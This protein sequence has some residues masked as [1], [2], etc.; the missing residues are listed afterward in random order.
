MA[1]TEH[2]DLGVPEIY[3]VTFRQ[4][5]QDALGIRGLIG[6]GPEAII[7]LHDATPQGH[8]QHRP[9]YKRM[10]STLVSRRDI[11]STANTTPLELTATDAIGVTCRRKIGPVDV[12][13]DAGRISHM[14]EPAI[15][16]EIATQAAEEYAANFQTSAISALMGIVASMSGTPHTLSVW[17]ATNRTNLDLDLIARGTGLMGDRDTDLRAIIMHSLVKTDLLRSQ[18][19][20]GFDTGA[21]AVMNEFDRI[22]TLGLTRVAL[23]HDSLKTADAGFNKFHTLLLGVNA[24]FVSMLTNVVYPQQMDLL[25]EQVIKRWR[26]DVDFAI[27][28]PAAQWDVTN[29]GANPTDAALATSTNWDGAAGANPYTDSREVKIVQLTH[30]TRTE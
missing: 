21:G 11:T 26:A 30:N 25:P 10:G 28:C 5:L 18:L 7:K 14:S 9:T 1:V 13:A 17:N 2:G 8:Y 15:W 23:Q 12:S 22:A 16:V 24:L 6:T 3:D 20:M 27:G 19:G 29:G 4:A